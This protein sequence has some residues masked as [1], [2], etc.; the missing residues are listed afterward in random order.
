MYIVPRHFRPE[1]WFS[2]FVCRKNLRDGKIRSQIWRLVDNRITWTADALRDYFGT[3]YMNNWF[4]GG[5]K[6]GRGYRDPRELIDYNYRPL[7][8]DSLKTKYSSFSSQHCL[9][10]ALDATFKGVSAKEIRDD[11]RKNKRAERYKFIACVETKVSWLHVD[12]RNWDRSQS[13]IL[14]VNP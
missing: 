3:M 7:E 9:G 11:I 14:F 10:R 5:D 4:W 13:G 2:Q 12:V 8:R 6:E 1:E